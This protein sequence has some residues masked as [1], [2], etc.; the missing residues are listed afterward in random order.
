M[1]ERQSDNYLASYGAE[2]A[3]HMHKKSLEA[4][5]VIRSASSRMR[6][7]LSHVEMNQS[8][9]KS[10][11]DMKTFVKLTI[12]THQKNKE[13]ACLIRNVHV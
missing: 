4:K 8:S 2:F 9:V 11:D 12:Q 13:C 1:F 7:L 6:M 5:P 10:C 3:H